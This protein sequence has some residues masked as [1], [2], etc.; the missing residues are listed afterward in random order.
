MTLLEPVN[1]DYSH[2]GTLVRF[3]DQPDLQAI[4]SLTDLV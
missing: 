1:N 2:T 4:Q 3:V